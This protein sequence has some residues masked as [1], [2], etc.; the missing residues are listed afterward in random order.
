MKTK[1][2]VKAQSRKLVDEIVRKEVALSL[3]LFSIV[4]LIDNLINSQLE[5]DY[6]AC[7]SIGVSCYIIFV[8]SMYGNRVSVDVRKVIRR[9]L[10]HRL[11]L[12][13]A[14]ATVLSLFVLVS[15][16]DTIKLLNISWLYP[17]IINLCIYMLGSL[18]VFEL[19]V[20]ITF[21]TPIYQKIF[22]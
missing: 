3:F 7:L 10:W 16:C 19:L 1:K 9:S 11:G 20:L 12:L 18:F 4:E 13:L 6:V 14:M 21:V 2:R 15:M 8:L 5:T 17:A 22:D